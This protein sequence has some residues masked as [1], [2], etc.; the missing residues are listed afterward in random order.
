MPNVKKSPK[1]TRAILARKM[2]EPFHKVP[3]ELPKICDFGPKHVALV[4][5]YVLN[6]VTLILTKKCLLC[7]WAL[8]AYVYIEL[9][10]WSLPPVT[11]TAPEAQ[12]R[13]K[14]LKSVKIF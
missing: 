8:T 1:I 11:T 12:K 6:L 7:V 14:R 9:E 4:I 3:Q 2:T 10:R 5:I 13:T